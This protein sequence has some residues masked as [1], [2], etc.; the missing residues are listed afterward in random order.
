MN[1]ALVVLVL[2]L[3]GLTACGSEPAELAGYVRTPLPVVADISLPEVGSDAG[4]FTFRADEDGLLLVYFGY[5]SCPD[6]CPTTL[7][8]VRSAMRQLG[9]EAGRIDLAMATVDPDRDT[10]DV[11]EAYVE[12]FVSGGH[13]LR[14]EDDAQ[15]KAAA[16][17][18]GAYYEV[19]VSDQGDIEV[20]HTGH[21]YVVDDQG[22]LQVTWPFGTKP[23]EIV[24]DLS[25]LLDA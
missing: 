18:F 7:A 22:R 25:I 24:S 3:L 12:A 6:V 11:I 21:L 23:A 16:D 5:T 13:P 2:A 9:D 14:T 8:D 19:S 17:A 1:R 20:V 10:D 15:L 4:D